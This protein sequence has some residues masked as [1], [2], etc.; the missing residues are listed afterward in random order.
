[1]R[2]YKLNI[3]HRINTVNMKRNKFF[4]NFSP[5]FSA[6]WTKLKVVQQ[7]LCHVEIILYN[8]NWETEPVLTLVLLN[9]GKSRANQ[10]VLYFL[11]QHLIAHFFRVISFLCSLQLSLKNRNM[12]KGKPIQGT[13]MSIEI[14]RQYYCSGHFQS[15]FVI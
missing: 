6:C 2:S 13:N 3:C 7:P 10:V 4:R 9:H 11:Q 8:V 5:L 12:K 1:M 14:Q 15:I